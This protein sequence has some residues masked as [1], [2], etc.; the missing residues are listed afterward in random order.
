M[1][2]RSIDWVRWLAYLMGGVPLVLWVF[3]ARDRVLRLVT[4]LFVTLFIHDSFV[5]RRY[6]WAFSLCA[7]LVVAYVA[8]VARVLENRR[9]PEVG[10]YGPLWMGLLF[11]AGI[12]VMAGSVG[13]GLL[14][15][16]VKEFQFSYLEG[17]IFFLYGVVALRKSEELRSFF[18]WMVAISALLA[19][20]HF[21]VSATGYHFRGS[22]KAVT[23]VYYGGVMDNGNSLGS[24]WVMGIP[25]ALAI[26]IARDTSQRMRGFCYVALVFMLG[27][28]LLS[29]SR[30]GMLFTMVGCAWIGSVVGV[31]V[32]RLLAAAAL[33]AVAAAVGYV[34]LRSFLAASSQTVFDMMAQ[35]GFQTNRFSIYMAYSSMLL[36]QPFGLGLA[37]ENVMQKAY[38]HGIQATNAHNIY[39]DIAVQTGVIG[40]GIFL[41]FVSSMLLRNRRAARITRDPVMKAALGQLFLCLIGFLGV[42]FF[43]PIYTAS[44]KMNNLFWLL[45]GLSVGAVNTV[46]EARRAEVAS[47]PISHT[48]STLSAHAPGV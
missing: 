48:P 26:A 32:G 38:R 8:L 17:L 27:S 3:F 18:H 12:S 20:Q 36:D 44:G 42:G 30:G 2:D 37:A 45:A 21:F 10:P 33:G 28:L 6:I 14:Q 31:R 47:E 22:P 23:G 29:G 4:V 24:Y 9:L 7:S 41:G 34:V 5:G 46:A 40:L 25:S 19:L 1:S 43:E 13:T 16:N 15:L 35:E 11:T 39:L